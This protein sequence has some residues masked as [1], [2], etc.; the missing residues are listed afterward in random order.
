MEKAISVDMGIQ[1]PFIYSVFKLK[2]V[3]IIAGI[4]TPPIDAIIGKEAF[5]KMTNFHRVL[6]LLFPNLPIKKI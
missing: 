6:L 5:L 1:I 2:Y 3:K 4:I